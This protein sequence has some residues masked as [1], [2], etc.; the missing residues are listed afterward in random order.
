M[1]G[2]PAL[3]T[4]IKL[5]QGWQ[6]IG[7]G[8]KWLFA[9]PMAA[10]ALGLGVWGVIEHR[11]AAKWEGAYHKLVTDT[12]R[13]AGQ[14][15]RDQAAVNHRPA[16]IS[17]D[18]AKRTDHE[19][20]DY[21]SGAMAAAR[22]YADAHRVR[23]A[24]AGGAIRGDLPGADHPAPRDDGPGDA[25]ELDAAA[26]IIGISKADFDSCT[27][28]SAR[29]AKVRDAAQELIAAG[30]AKAADEKQNPQPSH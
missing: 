12:Q 15:A 1:L 18:I 3:W 19:A 8:L 21:I 2:L 4:A 10:L 5:W 27:I 7:D 9:H 16:A 22:A 11:A 20:D 26:D 13:A 14:A 28:N 29:I 23:T 25:A 24:S 30:V 6:R 17:A